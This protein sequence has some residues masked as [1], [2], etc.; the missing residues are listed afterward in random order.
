M[1]GHPL[2]TEMSTYGDPR[3]RAQRKHHFWL[4]FWCALGAAFLVL[5]LAMSHDVGQMLVSG[6]LAHPHS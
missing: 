3:A 4:W 1:K 5:S 2:R 6:F